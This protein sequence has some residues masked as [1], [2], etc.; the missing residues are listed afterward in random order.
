MPT[1][2]EKDSVTGTETT[3][4]EWDGIKELN[5]PLPK[6]WLYIFYASIIWSVI[7]CIFMP[8][9]PYITGY[10]G[11]IWD[12]S[13]RATVEE[14]LA[15]AHQRQ[16]VFLDRMAGLS[17]EQV[18]EDPE[19]LTF[20]LAGGA[21]AFADNCAPCHALGGAGNPGGYPVLADDDWLWGGTMDDIMVTIRHGIRS[22]LDT[23]TRLATMPNFGSDGL[24]SREQVAAVADYV[25]SLSGH[26]DA[27]AETLAEG[28]EIF[29]AQCVS[30]HGA[31]GTGLHEFGAPNLTDAIWLYGGERSEVI[32][33]VNHP[34][35]GVMPA[36]EER[37][38]GQGLDDTTIRMLT[39]YVH[40]LGGGE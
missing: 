5:T 39:V 26:G 13:Q 15:A 17:P 25:L 22:D 21:A 28:A 27:G 9:V 10:F 36:W 2:V 19:L 32:A 4:H 12:Y 6:W 30:C 29:A 23:N 31:D 38:N 33:Q 20:A 40:S 3:G 18:A 34:R 14:Q 37:A 1:K 11:G 24:L 8:S 7:Y 16:S 35:L